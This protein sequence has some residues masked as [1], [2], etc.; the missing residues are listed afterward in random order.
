MIPRTPGSQYES[1]YDEATGLYANHTT[2][3][4]RPNYSSYS[5][6]EA[7]W[8]LD[9]HLKGPT[10][11]VS[12]SYG[13][14]RQAY[15]FAAHQMQPRQALTQTT[16]PDSLNKTI[17]PTVV[18][19]APDP[20]QEVAVLSKT[21]PEGPDSDH[22]ETCVTHRAR[23]MEEGTD[24]SV[25]GRPYHV[26]CVA[27]TECPYQVL[28]R[29]FYQVHCIKDFYSMLATR[30]PVHQQHLHSPMTSQC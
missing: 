12:S 3:S 25:I 21:L 28:G 13:Q 5:N 18:P 8:S 22:H 10:S 14:L 2:T 23:R 30:C 29:P 20:V 7:S 9:S 15:T 6:L 24:C 11:Q 16:T 19:Q 1:D 4:G 26:Q 17:I 27:C